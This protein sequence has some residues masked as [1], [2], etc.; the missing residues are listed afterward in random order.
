MSLIS[1]VKPIITLRGGLEPGKPALALGQERHARE[2][3]LP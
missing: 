2:L 1:R 3:R